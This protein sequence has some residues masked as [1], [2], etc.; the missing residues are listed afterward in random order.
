MSD[1]RIKQNWHQGRRA[2]RSSLPEGRE[3][4]TL[5]NRRTALERLAERYRRFMRLAFVFAPVSLSWTLNPLFEGPWQIPF[6]VYMVVYFL[7]AAMMDRSLLRG[8]SA[9]DVFNMPFSEVVDKALECRKRHLRYMAVTLPMAL[10]MIGFLGWLFSGEEALL[11]G[12]VLG[13][14]VGFSIGL[15]QLFRFMGDYR[16]LRG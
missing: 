1:E 3:L 2:L 4:E 10:V 11:L 5:I 13:A 9:I 15:Y 14:A 12:M 6:A 8:I 16:S 7:V